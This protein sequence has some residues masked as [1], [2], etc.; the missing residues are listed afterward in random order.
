MDLPIDFFKKV[1]L[2]AVKKNASS[3]HLAAASAPLI[4][5]NG[6]FFS[7]G[8][9]G[10]ILKK[11]DLEKI[12]FSFL[13]EKEVKM[14]EEKRELM[15]VK[16]FGEGFR[17]RIKVFYQKDCLS[18]SLNYISEEILSLEKLDL[19]LS[20]K[21]NLEKAAG[22]LIIAGPSA[23]GKTST[24]ASIIEEFNKNKRKYVMT[25]EDPIEK[26]FANKKSIIVQ[27]QIGRD[28]GSFL[29]GLKHCL[30]ED[31]DLVY[32]DEVKD[33]FE[34]ALPYILEL[35]SGNCLVILEMNAENS[36]RAL[37][38]ILNTSC[39]NLASESVHF[40]LADVLFG[41]IVQRL[42][43]NRENGLSLA[44]EVLIPN[45]AVKSLIREGGIYQLENVLNNSGEDGMISMEKSIKDLVLSGEIDRQDAGRDIN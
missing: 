13:S 23:S 33:S 29:D 17:F 8:E 45:F 9:E 35:A 19:P 37:E 28:V 6:R 3:I 16:E 2:E 26:V 34:L 27:R 38:K 31:V 4:R 42:L 32:I 41:I 44:L 5:V 39:R 21:R 43:P 22:L 7:E 20:F 10:D 1:L 40:M 14:L 24:A 36:I 12:T 11:E 25:L 18:L 15:I 30:E